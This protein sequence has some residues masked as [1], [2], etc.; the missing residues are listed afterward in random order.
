L[1]YYFK[2]PFPEELPDSVWMEKYCQIEWLGKAGMLGVS[3]ETETEN[4]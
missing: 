4:N 2:I 3:E 1:S